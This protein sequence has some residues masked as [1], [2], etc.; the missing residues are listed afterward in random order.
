MKPSVTIGSKALVKPVQ[1]LSEAD[2]HPGQSLSQC[3]L[4]G[5]SDSTRV[6]GGTDAS[7]EDRLVQSRGLVD[8]Y[9][10]EKLKGKREASCLSGSMRWLQT[11]WL[12]PQA[13]VA[14]PDWPLSRNRKSTQLRELRELVA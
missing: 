11:G 14:V 12:F 1:W 6:A 3:L 9:C 2:L 10:H 7:S 8:A 13:V 4:T 5:Q